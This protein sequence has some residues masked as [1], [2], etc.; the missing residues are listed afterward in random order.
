MN[1]FLV[2]ISCP[3]FN[4]SAFIRDALNGFVMQQT[5]FPFVA[6]VVDDAST[7]GEQEVI[8]AYLNEHFDFSE[9]TGYKQWET[10]DAYW[11]FARHKKNGNCH[12]VTVFLKRNLFREPGKKNSVV[13]EWKNTKY[14][15]IC[16]GDDYWI[17]PLK[18]Q[19]QVD[20]WKPIRIIQCVSMVL[21]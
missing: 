4:H 1:I 7:D 20:F 10:E 2:S 18:L 5:D 3:T 6:V 16:E 12:F 14:I 19:K 9:E 15:A 21:M 11:T 13:K 8:K 17:D